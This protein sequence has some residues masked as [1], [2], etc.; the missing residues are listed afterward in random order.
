M[1]M[2]TNQS[3]NYSNPQQISNFLGKGSMEQNFQ[4]KFCDKKF[5]KE[6][7]L[8]THMCVKKQRHMDINSTG[9]RFGFRAFQRFY[10]LTTNSKSPK[11]IDDF[12][13]SD[14]YIDFAKFGNH[15]SVLKPLYMDQYI[16]YVIRNGV[17]LKDWTKDFVY[18]VYINDLL[19]KEP[20]Q[21]ATERT[22]VEI[23]EWCEKNKVEFKN[24]FTTISANE[25]AYLIKTGRISPWVLYLSTTGGDLMFRFNEDHSKIIGEIIDPGIWARKF[26]KAEDDVLYIK[27]ILEQVGI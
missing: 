12:I 5:H 15:L 1:G 20:A 25:A 16:D 6:T 22:I 17:K 2:M 10:T 8:L 3:K 11:S 23:M 9:S 4:C 26:K 19:Q 21:S 18:D 14:F 27:G 7:T 24:F 13:R